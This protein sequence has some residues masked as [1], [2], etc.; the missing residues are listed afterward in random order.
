LI[1]SD[2]AHE[3]GFWNQE[4]NSDDMNEHA[5][6]DGFE[7]LFRTSPF[8]DTIGPFYYKRLEEGFIVGLPLYP[9]HCNARGKVHG[10]LITTLADVSMGYVV[11]FSQEPP[12]RM[13]TTSLSVDFL[14]AAQPGQWLESSVTIL[15]T[16]RRAAFADAT[17]NTAGTSSSDPTSMVARAHAVFLAISPS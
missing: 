6:R 17:I 7:P 10:G 15:K 14:G 16:G 9:K 13:I 1:G 11:A 8:L 4:V 12:L 3:T 2:A 5:I